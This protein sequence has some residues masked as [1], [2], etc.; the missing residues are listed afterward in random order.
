V[1]Q[2]K[3][4]RRKRKEPM[5]ERWREKECVLTLL[6]REEVKRGATPDSISR[7]ING[8]VLSQ[9]GRG[10]EIVYL[11]LLWEKQVRKGV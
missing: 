6:F 1:G 9:M 7:S 10:K 11:Q 3:K 5:P 2:T 8:P 4:K